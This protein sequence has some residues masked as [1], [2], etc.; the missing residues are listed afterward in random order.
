MTQ[1][2]AGRAPRTLRNPDALRDRH[3]QVDDAHVAPLNAWVR[4][5]RQRL[6]PT[7]IVPWFDPW[8]GGVDASILWLLEAPGPRATVERGGSG[9]V[10]SDN[11]DATAENTWRTRQ[12]AGVPRESTVLWN[13]IPYYLGSATAI[14]PT[15]GADVAAAGPLLSG[16]LDLL[17]NVRCVLLGGTAANRVWTKHAPAAATEL[18]V[19]RAPHPSPTN[20]NTRPHHRAAIVQA[21]RDARDVVAGR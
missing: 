2:D 10:S 12:E 8:D 1:R 11:N 16:L 6:G 17:P 19:I 9:F 15:R 13:V 7:A 21:W 4:T 18:V 14:E 5:L 20:L 3:A